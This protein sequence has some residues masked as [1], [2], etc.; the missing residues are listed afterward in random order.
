MGETSTIMWVSIASNKRVATHTTGGI[1]MSSQE[2]PADATI[3]SSPVTEFSL[4]TPN[5]RPYGITT[6]PD[7]NLWFT[8]FG[9]D[10]I[11][12]ITPS[13]AVSEFALPKNSD[14]K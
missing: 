13:G 3:P 12:R 14:E 9:S 7:G 2:F 1:S 10:K 4:P 5:S 8:E 11:G 6:G